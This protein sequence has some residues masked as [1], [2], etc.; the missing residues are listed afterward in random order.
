MKR[1]TYT[2]TAAAL[3]AAT[4]SAC[5]YM[6]DF[7][8]GSIGMNVGVD[9]PGFDVPAVAQEVPA[10]L[11]DSE[12]T[13]LVLDELGV[14]RAE[15]QGLVDRGVTL[16][17]P[18]EVATAVGVDIAELEAE[19]HARI[20]SIVDELADEAE[21]R[22]LEELPEGV[23]GRFDIDSLKDF[24]IPLDEPGDFEA[25]MQ[26]A[27]ANQ[28][29]D[30]TVA[31]RIDDVGDVDFP[32]DIELSRDDIS[33]YLA[34]IRFVSLD[35]ESNV[36]EERSGPEE[37]FVVKAATPAGPCAGRA[38]LDWIH[39]AHTSMRR[40]SQ[41]AEPLLGESAG[42]RPNACS[43]R[44]GGESSANLVEYTQSGFEFELNLAVSGNLDEIPLT[45]FVKVEV[46]TAARPLIASVIE[47]LT[48]LATND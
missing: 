15:A 19:L 22:M 9:V 23:H 18:V 5:E 10:R 48:F 39:Q 41:D 45:G 44:L 36:P 14:P 31:F 21:T 7:A 37:D 6:A 26:A 28:V 29:F 17:R 24:E 27:M 34:S 11:V 33:E 35:L 25:A 16:R 1:S 38:S 43:L 40:E 4:T 12:S 8:G 3:M 30:L 13:L 20:E 46:F 42:S 47:V 2:L 32:D